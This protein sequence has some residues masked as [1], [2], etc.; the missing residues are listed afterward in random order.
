MNMPTNP[1]VATNDDADE[2]RDEARADEAR[3]DETR[4][5]EMTDGDKAH[6]DEPVD[7]DVVHSGTQDRTVPVDTEG[8][9]MKPGDEPPA[10]APRLW[11]GDDARGLRERL[12]EAQLHF[13]DDPRAAI[14]AADELVAEAVDS[15]TARL[16]EQRTALGSWR[17]NGADDTEQQRVVLQRY[18][19]FLDRVLAL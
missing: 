14:E 15:F 16:A 7:A 5:A 2:R 6:A 10:P 8:A 17:D 18:R 3:V 9:E 13:L 19:D 12:K 1:M 11:T 4:T